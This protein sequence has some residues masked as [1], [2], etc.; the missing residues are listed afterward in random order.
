MVPVLK[1]PLRR[2]LGLPQCPRQQP[3]EAREELGAAEHS[4]VEDLALEAVIVPGARHKG[5]RIPLQKRRH[6]AKVPACVC[7]CVCVCV[8]E[9]ESQGIWFI[10]GVDPLVGPTSSDAIIAKSLCV[11]VGTRVCVQGQRT[12]GS[13]G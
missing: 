10:S 5:R 12:R 7:V 11:R 9:G 2:K 1:G 3:S 6:A 8:W 13:R 4:L